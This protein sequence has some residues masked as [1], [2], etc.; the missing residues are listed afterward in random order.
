MAVTTPVPAVFI[1]KDGTLIEDVPF[2]V[3]PAQVRLA[4]GVVEGLVLLA[5]SGFRLFVVSNQPGVARGYF[6]LDALGA[7]ETRIAELLRPVG[8]ELDGWYY[9]PHLP[10]MPDAC[11]CRKPQ[12]GLL[13]Q[14]AAEHRI[15]LTQ[16]WLIG[17]IL[18]DIEAG[19]RAG[20]RT[21]LVLAGS[22]TVWKLAPVRMPDWMA[23]DVAHAARLIVAGT[24]RIPAP[25]LESGGRHAVG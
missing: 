9:C 1:D 23:I 22:E 3:D 7:V 6:T 15:D 21:V 24:Y 16:S 5:Q 11:D 8:V 10:G 13:Y 17:D 20:C 4:P 12:P 2:N 14:A 18:D 25:T 19:H